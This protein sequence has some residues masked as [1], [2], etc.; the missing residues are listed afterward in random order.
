[1]NRGD[2]RHLGR[3]PGDAPSPPLWEVSEAM[4]ELAE[5]LGSQATLDL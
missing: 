3:I 4:F 1:V 5:R 2:H